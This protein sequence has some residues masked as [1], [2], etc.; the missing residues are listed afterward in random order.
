MG[1][2]DMSVNQSKT[3]SRGSCDHP[4]LPGSKK[5]RKLFLP[6]KSFPVVFRHVGHEFECRSVSLP[7]EGGHVTPVYFRGK[8]NI[9]NYFCLKN[10]F[11]CFL[12]MGD[13]YMSVN[14]SQ[15][16]SRRSCD[17]PPLPGSKKHRKLFLPKKSFPVVFRHV[18][19]EFECRSVSLPIEGGHV[20]PVYFR[21]KKNIENYFCLKNRFQ[22]FSGMGR[23]GYEWES[24]SGTIK[25]GHVTLLYFSGEKHKNLILPDTSFLERTETVGPTRM[26]VHFN[27]TSR[28]YR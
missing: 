23:R 16:T 11:Q 13:T 17:H 3:T 6:K 15:T 12:G 4:P 24:V 18:G 2:A 8:K 20:T 5:H 27:L 22:W 19:H 7:I 28:S 9:E 10:C 25:G 14:Q 26:T 21:G 1:N